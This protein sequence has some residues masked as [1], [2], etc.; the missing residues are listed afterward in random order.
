MSDS[1]VEFV[2]EPK[3]DHVVSVEVAATETLQW[4]FRVSNYSVNFGV[5]FLPD[6][7]DENQPLQEVASLQRYE[8]AETE[9]TGCF[10]ASSGGTVVL[11]WDNSYSRFRYV[12][13]VI[14]LRDA[15][16][17]VVDTGCL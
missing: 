15:C 5:N 6:S 12:S 2:V 13:C 10:T 8:A 1:Y 17:T 7:C 3:S 4:K 11:K 9:H 16:I 14:T